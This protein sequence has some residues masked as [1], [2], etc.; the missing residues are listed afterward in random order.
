MKK[1]SA[2]FR[3]S[4]LNS[5]EMDPA[6]AATAHYLL[7]PH[8]EITYA[9]DHEGES[10]TFS[11]SLR[12]VTLRGRRLADVATHILPKLDGSRGLEQLLRD[13]KGQF[14]QPEIQRCLDFLEGQRLVAR[15]AWP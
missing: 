11:S 13:L 10:L 6:P 4:R 1:F 14:T 9:Q 7:L 8:Y 5:T 2:A 15:S 3:S 12:Q